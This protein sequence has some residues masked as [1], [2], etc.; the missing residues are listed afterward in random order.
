MK[1]SFGFHLAQRRDVAIPVAMP[2]PAPVS[3]APGYLANEVAPYAAY[4]PQRIVSG[5]SGPLFTLRRADGATME[6]SAQTGGDYPDYAAIEAWAGSGIPTVATLY[7]Q[8]G[9]GR[10]MA[11]GTP[12]N[13]PGFDTRQ[14]F[15]NAAPILFD[16]YNRT[17]TAQNPVR[18]KFMQVSG[19]SFD[20]AN[21][22]VFCAA[23]SQV[24][25]NTAFPLAMEDAGGAIVGALNAPSFQSLNSLGSNING[26]PRGVDSS[27]DTIGFTRTASNRF[28]YSQGQVFNQSASNSS[29]TATRLRIGRANSG[30]VAMM[31]LFGFVLYDTALSEADGLSAMNSMN[32]AI[33]KPSAFDYH[34]LFIGDSITEGTGSRNLLN[35]ARSMNLRPEALVTNAGVHG[36]RLADD[37]ANRTVRFGNQFRAGM[38]NVAFISGGTN[39]LAAGTAGSSLYSD[40]TAPLVAYLASLD[41]TVFVA[42]ILPRTGGNWDAAAEARRVAYND[43]VRGNAANAAGILDLA[44]N[45]TMGN[46]NETS[47]TLYPDGLHPSSLGYR[48]LAGAPSGSFADPATYYAALRDALRTTAL[49]DSYAP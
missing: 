29:I 8:S 27:P 11:Q 28:Y 39:D 32:A 42:T 2:S 47:T 43:A 36:Q 9:N 35:T 38:P 10:H 37:A 3:T 14:R 26:V 17:A 44:S 45:P 16:G 24:S 48:Y 34:V 13:Q 22:S 15:G 21:A 23:Q 20:R 40:A 30:E 46:G 33:G 7:D 6:V 41:F 19:L 31:A 4:G 1:V 12:D 5:Y 25:F 18:Q 49:G